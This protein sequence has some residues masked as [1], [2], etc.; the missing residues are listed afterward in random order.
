VSRG[1]TS[2]ATGYDRVVNDEQT[3]RGPD[4][5]PS[6]AAPIL[7]AG[8]PGAPVDWTAPG[9]DGTGGTGP[10]TIGDG[11]VLGGI[12]TRLAAFLVDLFI[13]GCAAI[14]ISLLSSSLI[15]DPGFSNVVAA[16]GSAALAVAYFAV[17]WI[18]PWSATP[19]QR[20]A[21]LRVVDVATLQPIDPGRAVIR[22]LLLGSALNL[23]S[24]AAPIARLIG[25]LLIIW[26]FV[27]FATT[28]YGPRRQGL[29]DRWTRTLVVR[30]AEASSFPLTL[31]CFVIV[32]II[33]AAP[34]IIVTVAGPS[35]QDW[36]Q[37]IQRSAPR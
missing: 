8:V 22:S 21:S 2:S 7:S 17:A 37:E 3:T 11:L 28:V 19:G 34:L 26:P 18:S 36:L 33:L 32:L 23:L 4:E 15:A 5:P 14:A 12:G 16:V 6:R 31:G 25:A 30:P 9:A 10:A 24:F 1:L 35:L 27:L 13:L 29:H 20:L